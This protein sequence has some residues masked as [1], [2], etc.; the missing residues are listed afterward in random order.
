MLDLKVLRT[1]IR[2][3]H[4]NIC[5]DRFEPWQSGRKFEFVVHYFRIRGQGKAM[6]DSLDDALKFS[7][8]VAIP[9]LRIRLSLPHGNY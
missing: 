1:S 7:L 8:L 6:F 9:T 2:L 4:T 3:I 5:P